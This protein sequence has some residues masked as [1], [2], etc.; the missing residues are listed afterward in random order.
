MYTYKELTQ[1]TK[2]MTVKQLKFFYNTVFGDNGYFTYLEDVENLK[3][4][5]QEMGE[6]IDDYNLENKNY[7]IWKDGF[8]VLFD[9]EEAKIWMLSIIN[10]LMILFFF[11]CVT[12]FLV[13]LFLFFLCCIL[14]VGVICF[15]YF[16]WFL[17]YLVHLCFLVFCMLFT[18]DV[19]IIF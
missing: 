6:N 19:V 15:V 13:V 10:L 18:I 4:D 2:N 17:L 3:Y 5:L 16:M 7:Y 1:K 8:V 9:D 11:V 12:I 14:W